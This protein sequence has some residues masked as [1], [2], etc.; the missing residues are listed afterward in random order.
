VKN[1]QIKEWLESEKGR[2]IILASF[3]LLGLATVIYGVTSLKS[4]MQ[5]PFGG[6]KTG[7]TAYTEQKQ[8]EEITRL[9][10]TDTDGDSLSDYDE[11]FIY[12]TSLFVADT[13]S[14]GL[15]DGAE[16]KNNTDPLCA[17]GKDC[18]VAIA[19]NTQ[20]T[21]TTTKTMTPAEIRT[22]LLA[23]GISQDLLTGVDDATLQ[24]IYTETIGT[25]ASTET[26]ITAGSAS[27]HTATEIRTFF[28]TSGMDAATLSAISDAD[29]LISYQNTVTSLGYDPI[30]M[31]DQNVLASYLSGTAATTDNTTTTTTTTDKIY[32]AQELLDIRKYLVENGVSQSE[33]DTLTDEELIKIINSSN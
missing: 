20:G 31:T 24:Q 6:K 23:A 33:I 1:D 16:I 32:T 27:G 26:M 12:G 13:D 30:S 21:A 25:Q 29:L 10:A 15:L 18:G 11:K 22:A 8:A 2:K 7:W 9:Q 3:L 28:Q 19:E 4:K 5:E 14:D 17:E